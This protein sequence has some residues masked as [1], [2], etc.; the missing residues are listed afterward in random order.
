MARQPEDQAAFE[1][2]ASLPL[3]REG[4]V[5]PGMAVTFWDRGGPPGPGFESDQL[6]VDASTIRATRGRADRGR[7][8]FLISECSLPLDRASIAWLEHVV[9]SPMWRAAAQSAG[10]RRDGTK[11][12][13]SIR[14]AELHLERTFYA[15]IPE[16]L[17]PLDREARALLDR[18]LQE[19][20]CRHLEH[21]GISP[22]PPWPAR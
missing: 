22:D 14:S 6:T 21:D 2:D 13:F 4:R 10:R 9:A 20:T 8:M 15:G 7:R 5:P 1:L 12:T 19:G 16:D 18:A 3:L 11:I 17:V